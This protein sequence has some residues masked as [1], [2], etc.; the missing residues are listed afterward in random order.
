MA[1]SSWQEIYES[2]S[3][4]ELAV[5]IAALKKRNTGFSAQ[6]S[7]SGKSYQADLNELREQLAAAIRVQ[8]NRGG[9]ATPR[10][11]V[12]DFSGMGDNAGAASE[13]GRQF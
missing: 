13:P 2:Y 4:S 7:P 6:G 1:S 12:V 9:A 5:E 8:T 10:V 3:V 11:G